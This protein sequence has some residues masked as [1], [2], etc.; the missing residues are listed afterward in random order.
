M[1]SGCNF[2]NPDNIIVECVKTE[3]ALDRMVL[4]IKGKGAGPPWYQIFPVD[5]Y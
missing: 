1:Q 5:R 3:D 2:F 4:E